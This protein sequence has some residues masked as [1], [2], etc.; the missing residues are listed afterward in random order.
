MKLGDSRWMQVRGERLWPGQ[1]E[2]EVLL[3]VQLHV[4]LT[5]QLQRCGCGGEV[6]TQAEVMCNTASV[7]YCQA[8]DVVDVVHQHKQLWG[9]F[10]MH[11]NAI[12]CRTISIPGGSVPRDRIMVLGVFQHHWA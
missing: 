12:Q 5:R 8:A 7:L 9:K 3:H 1:H 2:H 10:A 6:L 11:V 4:C